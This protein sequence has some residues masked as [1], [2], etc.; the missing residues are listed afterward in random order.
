[1]PRWRTM[2]EPAVTSWPSPALT[3]SRW[4]TLSRPF[5][6]CRLPSCGPCR[7]LVLLR[8]GSL[9]CASPS[10]R[11]CFGVRRPRRSLRRRVGRLGGL[12]AGRVFLPRLGSARRLP[13]PRPRRPRPWPAPS[14]RCARPRVGLRRASPAVASFAASSASVAACAAAASSRRWRSVLASASALRRG[15]GGALAAERDVADAQDR[16]LLAVALLDAAAGLGAV[17][18]GDELL[19]AGL[20]DDLGAD[21]GVRDERAGRSTPRRRRRRAGRGRA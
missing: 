13:R 3:P 17:L 1:M 7:L 8:C 5:L 20:A 2:I 9:G 12:R 10:G 18:E 19:A 6:S 11:G 16:Q 21:G 14:S 4:P 15:L